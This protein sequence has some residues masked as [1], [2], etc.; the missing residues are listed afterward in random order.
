VEKNKTKR[1][2]KFHVNQFFFIPRERIKRII[3]IMSSGSV[4]TADDS[5]GTLRSFMRMMPQAITVITT[6]T[7][8]AYWG[9]TISSIASASLNPP[10][11]LICV[12]RKAPSYRAIVKR[13]AFV[14]NLLME[15]Q[16]NVSDLFAGRFKGKDKFKDAKFK[17]TQNGLPI[18]D[19][20][21]GSLE[22]TLW[23]TYE[24]GDHDIILGRVTGGEVGLG[25]PI[26]YHNQSYAKLEPWESV[27]S[28]Y[29][30]Y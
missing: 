27:P 11:I 14:V 26:I 16:L 10:L 13:G 25:L 9:I 3:P 29:P 8:D 23:K 20:V 28:M 22:C 2:K 12:D 24:A 30:I 4:H 17:L 1:V 6:A 5:A 15:G 7:D 19:G 18:L 21:L